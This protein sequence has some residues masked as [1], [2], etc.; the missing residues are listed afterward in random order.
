MSQQEAP[1]RK[2]DKHHDGGRDA[3]TCDN[4]QIPWSLGC[5]SIF[6]S[7][8]APFISRQHPHESIEIDRG[9][10]IRR[11]AASMGALGRV[12]LLSSIKLVMSRG[13][14]VQGYYG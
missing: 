6:H 13:H 12:D 9:F 5:T 3:A 7:H 1:A 2:Q 14:G 8:S 4:D 10:Q 11:N